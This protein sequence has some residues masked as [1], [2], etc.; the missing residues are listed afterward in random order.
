MFKTKTVLCE[1]SSIFNGLGSN[2]TQFYRGTSI[3]RGFDQE[4]T[5]HVKDSMVNSGVSI[6][7]QTEVQSIKKTDD[8]FFVTDNKN[9]SLTVDCVLFA[10]G[11]KPQTN[12]LGLKFGDETMLTISPL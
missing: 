7:L 4:I 6:K 9:S 11:R 1:F 10:T 8:G 2:V 5:D 3:L 12:E